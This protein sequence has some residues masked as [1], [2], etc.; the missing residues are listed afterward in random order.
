MEGFL[1]YRF[2]GLIF[3]GAYIWR[4]L[5]MEGLIFGILRYANIGS[6]DYTIFVL[7]TYLSFFSLSERSCSS[8]KICKAVIEAT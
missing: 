4:G 6:C 8:C 1:H 3:G 7:S 5:N 2:G